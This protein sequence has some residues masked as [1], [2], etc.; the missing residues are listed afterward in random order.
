MDYPPTLPSKRRGKSRDI[1]IE[2]DVA[3]IPLT[4]GYRA[5]VDAE[6]VPILKG[7][8]W[9]ADVRKYTQY[10]RA[11]VVI[12]GRAINVKM[13]KFL[14]PVEDGKL[15]D[16][17]NGNGLDNRK[18]NLRAVSRSE[19]ARNTAPRRNGQVPNVRFNRG[20]GNFEG[21]V[22]VGCFSDIDAA[23]QAVLNAEKK[24]G[25][26]IEKTPHLPK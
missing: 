4:N 18:A 12:D 8:N 9:S 3:Y 2:G 1:D 13:H 26:C 19:N 24:L 15:V 11:M 10:A 5:I 17:V 14:F 16:H 7:R 22:F 21:Y 25:L 23:K 6:D 20:R